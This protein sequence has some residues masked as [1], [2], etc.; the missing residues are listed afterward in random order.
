MSDSTVITGTVYRRL[1]P[2]A[3]DVQIA[4]VEHPV[5][6]KRLWCVGCT[7]SGPYEY[8]CQPIELL[9]HLQLHAEV[10]DD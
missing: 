8:F 4:L 2:I 5:V 1:H 9:N 3:R 6:G 10:A 7:L